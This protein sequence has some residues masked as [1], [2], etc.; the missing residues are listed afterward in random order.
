[1]FGLFGDRVK[2]WITINE[3]WVISTEGHGTGEMAPGAFNQK[4]R[5]GHTLIL[6]HSSAYRLYNAKYKDTQKGEIGITFSSGFAEGT[7]PSDP[8]NW[9]SAWDS[10]DFELG[11][12][13]E[14]IFGSGDYPTVMRER[15]ANSSLPR[16]FLPEFTEEEKVNNRG[17]DFFGLNHYT[18]HLS[19]PA[20]TVEGHLNTGC[21]NWPGSGS[22]W[23]KQVP[24]GFRKLLRYVK[25][26]YDNPLIY[27]TENGVSNRTGTDMNLEVRHIT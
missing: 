20:D 22:S 5:A 23:L 4:Y 21:I 16:N 6:A 12:F 14:P 17:S 13:A 15:L 18:T 1:M 25:R 19:M 7:N 11:W 10:L 24:W 2:E 26:R 27:V 8:E 9:Q 3:P